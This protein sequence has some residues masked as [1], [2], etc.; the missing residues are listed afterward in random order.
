ELIA[1]EAGHCAQ[2]LCFRLVAVCA[3]LLL[4]RPG[5]HGATD[6]RFALSLS[7]LFSL[8]PRLT[9]VLFRVGDHFLSATVK[10]CVGDCHRSSSLWYVYLAPTSG[11]LSPAM[12]YAV[13]RSSA[14]IRMVRSS[15][16]V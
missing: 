14:R 5:Q 9:A 8:P 1:I 15:C 11:H 3:G 6:P 7:H 13:A 12:P 4:G 10:L 2:H 16:L